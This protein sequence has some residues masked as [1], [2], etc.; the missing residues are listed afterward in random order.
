MGR[1]VVVSSVLPWSTVLYF[2]M[3]EFRLTSFELLWVRVI[4]AS[5]LDTYKYLR[6]ERLLTSTWSNQIV[7]MTTDSLHLSRNTPWYKLRKIQHSNPV[8]QTKLEQIELQ[9]GKAE[10]VKQTAPLKLKESLQ[11]LQLELALNVERRGLEEVSKSNDVQVVGGTENGEELE[12]QNVDVEEMVEIDLIEIGEVVKW[13]EIEDGPL[14][15]DGLWG[16]RWKRRQRRGQPW[17]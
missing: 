16:L 9:T 7:N 5:R 15:D 3:S 14:C 2:N 12:I 11:L 8:N 4:P 6:V 10:A 13:G 17:R 1:C